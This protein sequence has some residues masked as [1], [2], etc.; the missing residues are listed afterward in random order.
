MPVSYSGNVTLRN[1][2]FKCNV[3]YDVEAGENYS[4]GNFTFENLNIT[5]EKGNVE[6]SFIKNFSVKNVK[7]N[8][9]AID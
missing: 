4:L 7:V 9:A 2:D 8:G 5:A 3:F 6:K 1:I